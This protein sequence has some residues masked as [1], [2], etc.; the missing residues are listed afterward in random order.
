MKS[1]R[2]SL[3]VLLLVLTAAAAFADVTVKM[4]ISVSGGPAAMDMPMVS[5]VKGMKMRTDMQI[6]TQDVSIL[7]DVVTKQRLMID[8]VAKQ[9]GDFDPKAAMA[10]MPFDF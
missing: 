1:F 2:L 10:N 9:V 7:L 8:H 4:T 5:Y 3:A 6:M